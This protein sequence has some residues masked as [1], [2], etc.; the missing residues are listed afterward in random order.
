MRGSIGMA[1]DRVRHMA[2][3]NAARLRPTAGGAVRPTR[4]HTCATAS[5]SPNGVTSKAMPSAARKN[6]AESIPTHNGRHNRKRRSKPIRRLHKRTGTELIRSH[7]PNLENGRQQLCRHTDKRRADGL[8]LPVRPQAKR[9]P[10]NPE[11][12]RPIS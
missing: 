11:S 8:P 9:F 6:R 10:I 12:D 4:Q 5:R 1:S 3:P 7:R 2:F